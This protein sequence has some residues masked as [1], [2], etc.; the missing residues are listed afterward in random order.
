MEVRVWVDRYRGS[1]RINEHKEREE[2]WSERA[3]KWN[4]VRRRGRLR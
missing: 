3:V 4:L 1:W 2:V